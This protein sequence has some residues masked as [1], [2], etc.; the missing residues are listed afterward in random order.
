MYFFKY[1]HVGIVFI[2][3][4]YNNS[5]VNTVARRLMSGDTGRF[6]VYVRTRHQCGRIRFEAISSHSDGI[7]ISVWVTMKVGTRNALRE[8]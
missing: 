3:H 8:P 6:F 5:T 7:S 1:A 2:C 4:I